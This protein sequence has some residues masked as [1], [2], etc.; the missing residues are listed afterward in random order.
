M[1]SIESESHKEVYLARDLRSRLQINLFWNLIAV[2][3]NQGGTF[4]IQ[5][6]I[7]RIMGR[8]SYGEYAMIYVTLFSLATI[9]QLATGYTVTRYL[10][11]YH[12][13]DKVRAGR[14]MGLCSAICTATGCLAVLALLGGAPWL[15]ASALKAPHLASSLMIGAGYLFFW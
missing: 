12:S 11:E 14:I 5:I 7:A 6:I 15:A 9:S 4:L 3:F 8:A 2:I 1:A 13:L 10:A